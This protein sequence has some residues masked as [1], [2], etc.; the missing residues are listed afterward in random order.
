MLID[1]TGERTMRSKFSG[2]PARRPWL[3]L[4]S[5][6]MDLA[7]NQAGLL[8]HAERAWTSVTFTGS[9]HTLALSFAGPEGIAAGER[10]IAALPDHEFEIPRHLV[11]DAA[12]VSVEHATVP[13]QKLTVECELLLLEDV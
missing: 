8:R 3:P 7:E 1:V 11:A 2:R 12:I 10:F 4:L 6:V 13:K 9:R 5:A